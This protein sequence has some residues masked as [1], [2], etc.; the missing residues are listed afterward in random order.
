MDCGK[1]KK[2]YD[3]LVGLKE[4]GDVKINTVGDGGGLEGTRDILE[5][6]RAAY[7]E[8]KQVIRWAVFNR[9]FSKGKIKEVIIEDLPGDIR[10][11]YEDKDGF[12][13]LLV[14]S[15]MTVKDAEYFVVQGDFHEKYYVKRFLTENID[16][17]NGKLDRLQ[18]TH[19]NGAVG[20]NSFIVEYFDVK[21]DRPFYNYSPS[22]SCELNGTGIEPGGVEAMRVINAL[23]LEL[24]GAP[25]HSLKEDGNMV[26]AEVNLWD[27]LNS[28]GDVMSIGADKEIKYVF[29]EK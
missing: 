20:F 4:S 10:E 29:K 26:L 19:R 9:Y 12:F 21:K 28:E 23:S 27:K 22:V 17:E 18:V 3:K 8:L 24:Y 25:L 7:S 15:N 11:H 16:G 1:I 6:I 14:L 2:L 13:D 5:Q